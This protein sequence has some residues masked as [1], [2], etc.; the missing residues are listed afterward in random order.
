MARTARVPSGRSPQKNGRSIV[1][2]YRAPREDIRFVVHDVLAF[3][4]DCG[5][6]WGDPG[7][8]G[9]VAGLTTLSPEQIAIA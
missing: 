8:P 5:P 9:G 3:E 7:L 4:H 6:E 2:S 1:Y